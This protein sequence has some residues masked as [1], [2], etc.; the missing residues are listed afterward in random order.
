[1]LNNLHLILDSL[2]IHKNKQIILAG[3]FNLFLDTTLEAKGGSPCLKKK[4]VA[5]SIKIKVNFDLCDIWRLRNPDA[6]Q[7]TFR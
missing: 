4:S 7:F 1:M 6:K 5:K 2:Y 3:D